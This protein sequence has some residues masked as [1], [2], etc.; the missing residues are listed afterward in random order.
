MKKY[1]IIIALLV[2]RL[3]SSIRISYTEEAAR[4]RVDSLPGQRTS[5][6]SHQFRCLLTI[7]YQLVVVNLLIVDLLIFL[8]DS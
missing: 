6:L 3:I 7:L 5:P 4:D 8:A 2:G 1:T